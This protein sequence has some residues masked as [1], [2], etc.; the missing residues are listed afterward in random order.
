MKPHVTHEPPP[1][2]GIG[3]KDLVEPA[4]VFLALDA[5]E[6]AVQQQIELFPARGG[7]IPASPPGRF[8][9]VALLMQSN[10]NRRMRPRDF[11]TALGERF[12]D[13]AI[14]CTGMA[15]A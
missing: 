4:G 14:A 3:A 5:V 13:A 8:W 1:R 12:I 9:S 15:S 6:H 2:L 11:D 7:V 10:S